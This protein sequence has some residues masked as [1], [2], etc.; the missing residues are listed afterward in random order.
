MRRRGLQACGG[1][2]LRATG[3][4]TGGRLTVEDAYAYAK[5]ARAVLGTND[6]DFRARQHCA[7]RPTSWPTCRGRSRGRGGHLRR[8]GDRQ[9]GAA[10]RFEA[11][12]EA[13]AVFLRLRKAYRKNGLKS[14]TL[15]PYLERRRAQAGRP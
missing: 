11:E 15:A 1:G 4:L 3:R 10:G 5:F 2:S 7:R 12:E 9:L 14:W 6:I 8:S 13:G